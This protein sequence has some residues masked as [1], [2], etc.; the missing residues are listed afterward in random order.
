MFTL[1]SAFLTL[2]HLTLSTMLQMILVIS[3]LDTGISKDKTATQLV[4]EHHKFQFT[5]FDAKACALTPHAVL[6]LIT[7]RHSNLT[8]M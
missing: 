6:L 3:I 2:S 4:G 7:L 8:K 1:S 5:H